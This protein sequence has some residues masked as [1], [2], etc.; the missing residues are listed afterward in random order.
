MRFLYGL[1]PFVAAITGAVATSDAD[2]WWFGDSLF[3]LGPPSS[4]IN[5]TKATYSILPP[6]VP[7]GYTVSNPDDE[8]WVA[9][10]VGASSTA[11]SDYANLYQPVF[12][13]SP[14]QESQGC[15]ASETEWCVAASTYT[16][17]GQIGQP[18]VTVPQG[19]TVDF[20]IAVVGDNVV[21]TVTMGGKVISNQTEALDSGLQ[22][23]YSSNECYTGSGS[24]GTIDGYTI[25]NLTVT[26]SSADEKF[27]SVMGL[28]D[29]TASSFTSADGG[30]T[31]H[32]DYINTTVV[33]FDD[34]AEVSQ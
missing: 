28:Y 8:I 6:S 34:S 27:A 2:E 17:S 33:D 20:E 11:G 3:Y 5:I 25:S 10:W 12:D 26:L 9:V 7:C 21:Q 18:Y 16:P 23:L 29:V 19:T 4:G 13:W 15:P 31:W 1:F 30:I 14:N 32:A 24:C 22:Y